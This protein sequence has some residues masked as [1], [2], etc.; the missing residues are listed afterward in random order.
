[1]KLLYVEWYYYISWFSLRRLN[2]EFA[3]IN[4]GLFHMK[5]YPIISVLCLFALSSGWA[6]QGN[7]SI[8]Y[9]QQFTNL[10]K[11]SGLE[12]LLDSL[13]N[14]RLTDKSNPYLS[15]TDLY[16]VNSQEEKELIVIVDEN[17]RFPQMKFSSHIT[18]LMNNDNE[19]SVA[20]YSL[21][22][23]FILT[24]LRADWAIDGQFIPKDNPDIKVYSR[25]FYHGNSGIQVTLIL[26]ARELPLLNTPPEMTAFRFREK[27]E[28]AERD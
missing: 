18:N 17:S 20:F 16:L 3:V 27:Q 25:S 1:M 2:F 15:D 8:I 28:G 11:S 9:T 4:S 5:I 19:H 21:D 22:Q 13:E 24:Q 23:Y 26:L 10:L 12:I 7:H 14:Y 6:Q